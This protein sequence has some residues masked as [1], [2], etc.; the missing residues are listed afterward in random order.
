M[1]ADDRPLDHVPPEDTVVE[2]PPD[3]Q[4]NLKSSSTWLR[5]LFML[6]CSALY[7][8]TRFVVFAVVV[9]QFFW[10]LLTSEPNEKLTALGHSLALYSCEIIDYLTYYSEERPFPFDRDWPAGS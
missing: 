7:A 9:L 4:E 5:L 8:V 3:I 2:D 10:A 1:T 6:V